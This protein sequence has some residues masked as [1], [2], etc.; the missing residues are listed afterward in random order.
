M[1]TNKLFTLMSL[2]LAGLMTIATEQAEVI[3]VDIPVI[4]KD[5]VIDNAGNTQPMWTFGGEIP[6]PLVRVKQGDTV[7]FTM[8]N[9][10]D[11]KESHSMDFHA[12]V[13]DVL[14][15]FAPVKQ[16]KRKRL[17][18]KPIIPVSLY[19]TAVLMQCQNILGVVCMV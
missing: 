7:D 17:N 9:D 1:K 8:L 13:V 4:E 18:L 11:N 3:K 14:D 10:K 16:V 6:G 15:E 12:A 2:S 19:T 5:V